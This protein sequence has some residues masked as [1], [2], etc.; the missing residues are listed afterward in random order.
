MKNKIYAIIGLL[1]LINYG[2]ERIERAQQD[3][4]KTIINSCTKLPWSG[5]TNHQL[6]I[7]ESDGNRTIYN[8]WNPFTTIESPLSK[9]CIYEENIE[10][11]LDVENMSPKERFTHEQ[12][13]LK[14][15]R[16]W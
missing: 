6:E 2:C 16:N 15:R 11:C 9:V 13:F 10:K 12:E 8:A 1:G 5:T 14:Y 4:N 3:G 7:I